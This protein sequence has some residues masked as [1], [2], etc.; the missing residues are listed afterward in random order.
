MRSVAL[1]AVRAA[2]IPFAAVF[3]GSGSNSDQALRTNPDNANQEAIM[4]AVV[5]DL[6]DNPWCREWQA[7]RQSSRSHIV[8]EEPCSNSITQ[9]KESGAV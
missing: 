4:P 8:R 9:I 3:Q 5:A 2:N 7:E 1:L 6:R